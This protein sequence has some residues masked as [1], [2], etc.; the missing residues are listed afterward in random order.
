EIGHLP[1]PGHGVQAG[2]LA[3]AVAV[4]VPAA[5]V[6]A[7]LGVDRDHDALSAELVGGLAD[8]FGPGDRGRVE[9][10]LV[11]PCVEHAAHIVDAAHTTSHGQWD[12]D[13][14]SHGL[15]DG[16]DQVAAIAGG[17]DVEEGELV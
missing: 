15:D 13:L 7:A 6:G 2:V 8:E 4:D 1:G 3:P 12:E 11:G 17:G 9:A 14:R 10:G 16:Q 5:A